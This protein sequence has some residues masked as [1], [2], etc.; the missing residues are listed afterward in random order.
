VAPQYYALSV[1]TAWIRTN[2]NLNI[3]IVGCGGTG[4]YV[5]RDLTRLLGLYQSN[6]T[7]RINLTLI[8]KDVVENKNLT[9]QNFI[10][11]DIGKNKAE[12]LATR[13]GPPNGLTIGFVDSYLTDK[14]AVEIFGK[15]DVSIIIGC[16]DN[17]ATRKIIDKYYKTRTS[18]DSIYIDAGNTEWTGQVVL[19][20]K[21]FA[22]GASDTIADLYPMDGDKHPDDT[23]CAEAALS[24]PQ[25]ILT[26]I[27]AANIIVSYMNQILFGDLIEDRFQEISMPIKR[28]NAKTGIIFG[29]MI[30]K[31]N[32]KYHAYTALP[33]SGLSF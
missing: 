6:K 19:S 30:E 2:T 20:H 10:R 3:F 12:V 28:F 9:R 1:G 26:N 8:D 21:D 16:V 32:P 13:Y 23:S 25:N 11:N 24:S 15:Y 5:V 4:G 29:E 22:G 7:Q 27:M 17:N 31:R 33:A 14:N 18:G